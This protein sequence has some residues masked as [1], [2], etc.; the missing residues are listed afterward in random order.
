MVAGFNMLSFDLFGL[1]R[2]A[3]DSQR[4]KLAD[5]RLVEEP[6]EPED[7][8]EKDDDPERDIFFW[9]LYPVF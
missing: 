1:G 2:K 6:S 5:Q 8:D 3:L 9:S 7:V 4:Q